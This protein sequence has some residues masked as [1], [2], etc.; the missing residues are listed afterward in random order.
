MSLLR[1]TAGTYRNRVLAVSG[2]WLPALL[3]IAGFLAL[4]FTRP[5]RPFLDF[6][7]QAYGW[8]LGDPFIWLVLAAA[9]LALL[10]SF[11]PLGIVRRADLLILI[12]GAGFALGVG[13]LLWTA[14]PFGLGA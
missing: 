2:A 13:W 1:D 10:V 3:S 12:G 8:Q 11:L 9:A 6:Q 14:E 4:P 5:S 7:N